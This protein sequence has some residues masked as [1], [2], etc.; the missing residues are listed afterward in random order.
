M[1]KLSNTTPMRPTS[2]DNV[3]VPYVQVSIHVTQRRLQMLTL[4]MSR[5]STD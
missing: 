2:S 5:N 1:Y 3:S 4:K